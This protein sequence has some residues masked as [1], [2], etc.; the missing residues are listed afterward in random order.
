MANDAIQLNQDDA[1]LLCARLVTDV[2]ST[3]DDLAA[4][5]R[6]VER[7][8]EY[9]R[10]RQPRVNPPWKGASELVV[11]YVKSTYLAITSHVV[12]T[13][14][15]V[16]PL[17]HVVGNN[18]PSMQM[19]DEMETFYHALYTRKMK[20]RQKAERVFMGAFRDGTSIARVVWSQKARR[21][22]GWEVT[23]DAMV[24]PAS[25]EML[26]QAGSVREV[27]MDTVWYDAPEL[28][29]VPIER[30]GTFPRANVPIE[31]SPGVFCRYTLTGADVQARANV[32]TFDAK[33]TARLL[34][35]DGDASWIDDPSTFTRRVNQRNSIDS[36]PN[37]QTYLL[38]EIYYRYT[39]KN[40]KKGQALGDWRIVIHEPT[41]TLLACAP[42]PWWHGKRPYVALSPYVDVE[43]L[44]GDSIASA[45]AGQTQ[46]ALTTL[47]RLA[48]DA[49]AM[50]IAPEVLYASS[51]G[52]KF[53]RDAKLSR[54]PG[55]WLMMPDQFF[56]N[57]GNLMTHL[58][59][60][61]YDPNAAIAM[62]QTID[63]ICGQQSTGAS[64]N[65]K[66]TAISRDVTATE[67]SQIME[68]SQKT[69]QF[70]TERC[71]DFVSETAELVHGL[72]YQYQGNAYPQELWQD[73]CGES[74]V[75]MFSAMQGSYVLTSNGV[76]DT[77]NR[78]MQR[79]LALE[80]LQ[81][82]R[83]EPFVWD[84]VLLRHHAYEDFFR[85]RGVTQLDRVIG[86]VDMWQQKEQEAKMQAQA[87][88]E[89]Q[90][91]D[92]EMQA[93]GEGAG[94]AGVSV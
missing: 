7:Y 85:T 75:D 14:L 84:D 66:Q 81:L 78:A 11:P 87:M 91:V 40:A 70:L 63:Q 74:G 57:G 10:D 90:N 35:F 44:Y 54:G 94:D 4:H 24:D 58:Q 32:G 86:S 19:A 29:G 56:A 34:Q 89:M 8:R 51:L 23:Q 28:T 6:E 27:P 48:V 12:P 88:M 41:Q 36:I 47:L 55:A 17:V 16:D 60:N 83:Q 30:F 72:T 18:T 93:M 68:S 42:S 52:E 2:Q 62:M 64:D 37:D 45:G 15:G 1:D 65:L 59:R 76:R 53:A 25:G 79:Q 77:A 61:G 20:F 80:N 82:L 49:M 38:T 39:P 67:A 5:V 46:L 9:F 22:I 50:G 26:A 21:G 43:G 71:A 31:E 3:S 69:L 33:A 13:L 73:V 92:A